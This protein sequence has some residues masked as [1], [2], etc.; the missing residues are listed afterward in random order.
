MNRSALKAD[1]AKVRAWQQR[2]ASPKPKAN[3]ETDPQLQAKAKVL[4]RAWV[5]HA[6]AGRC[7]VCGARYPQGHHAVTQQQIK[8]SSGKSGLELL[9]LLWDLRN[10]VTLCPTHH[11][12]HHAR[13]SVVPLQALPAAVVEYAQDAGDWALRAL[14]RNHRH[15]DI[16]G[17]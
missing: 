15:T 14:H 5:L 12:N 1:P 13:S 4:H 17:L 6:R 3:V 16:G 2:S 7:I 11:A 9:V 10:L 8:R